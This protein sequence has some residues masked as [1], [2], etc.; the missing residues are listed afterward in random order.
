MGRLPTSP[1]LCEGGHPVHPHRGQA[2]L[3]TG[4][5]LHQALSC[6]RS[7]L[8]LPDFGEGTREEEEG[9][10]VS[11]IRWASPKRGL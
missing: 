2:P 4:S 10:F 9:D 5:E 6:L 11:A 1:A 7:D 8:E 3:P